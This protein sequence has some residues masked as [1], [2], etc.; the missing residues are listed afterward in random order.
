MEKKF[1][2]TMCNWM[3]AFW[4]K[5]KT[6]VEITRVVPATIDNILQ[7]YAKTTMEAEELFWIRMEVNLNGIIAQWAFQKYGSDEVMIVKLT[8]TMKE[9]TNYIP[10]G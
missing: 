4:A 5:L 1:T 6:C 10:R 9:P 2:K 7:G 8:H 3:R